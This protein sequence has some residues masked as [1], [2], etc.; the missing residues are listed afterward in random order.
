MTTRDV[1]ADLALLLHPL[2]ARRLPAAG[3]PHLEGTAN[4]RLFGHPLAITRSGV[5]PDEPSPPTG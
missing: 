4:D 3:S 5:R 1:F 2:P